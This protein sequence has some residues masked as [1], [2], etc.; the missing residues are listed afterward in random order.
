VQTILSRPR[1]SLIPKTVVVFAW[2]GKIPIDYRI[3]IDVIRFDGNRGVNVSLEAWWRVFN[4][5]GKTMLLSSKSN[6]SEPADGGNYKS[7]VAAQ[8]RALGH[9]SREIAEA[10][11]TL[12]K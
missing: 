5:D 2:R 11:K 10:I 4:G 3:E 6:L 9:L 12:P 7:L 8:S 1:P